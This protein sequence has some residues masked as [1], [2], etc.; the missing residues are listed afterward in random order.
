MNRAALLTAVVPVLLVACG[1]SRTEPTAPSAALPQATYVPADGE[2]VMRHLV[3]PRSLAFGPEG[4]LYVTEAGSGGS[5]PC[6]RTN[7]GG[8]ATFCYGP[9][10]AVSRLWHGLQ[11]RVATGLPSYAQVNSG[12]GE[13]PSG[14]AFQGLGNAYVTIGLEESPHLRDQAPEQLG[15][16]GTLVHLLPSA[17]APGRRP[18]DGD[19]WEIVADLAQ[20]EL[21]F[22]PDCGDLDSNPFSLMMDGGDAIVADAG[23]NAFIRVAANGSISPFAVFSNNTT[24]PGEGCPPAATRDF[25][26][27][28]ITVGPDGAYYIG[29]LNGFPLVVGGSSIYRME[30]DGAPEVA[31]TGFTFIVAIAFDEAGNLYVLQNSD[32]PSSAA[33]GSLVRVAPDGTRSTVVAGLER[34]SGLAIGPDGGIYVSTIPGKNYRGEGYVL[35]FEP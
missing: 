7:T 10:G 12:R 31:L 4:A 27:T 33:P 34:A 9:T 35:R 20:Y 23:A 2:I 19:G 24:K 16:L 25:V 29:H 13:G 17:L 11:E 22:N 15:G 5:G 1:E 8:T 32:G 30:R 18:D 28:T 14:I 6:F 26:P 21:D 3:S